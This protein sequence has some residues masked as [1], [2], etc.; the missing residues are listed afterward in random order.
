M[1]G[2]VNCPLTTPDETEQLD[3][4]IGLPSH[5][6]TQDVS[7]KLKSVPVRV[8]AD[9]VPPWS[10]SSVILGAKTVKVSDAEPGI[11]CVP[12]VIVIVYDMKVVG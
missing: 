4:A 9:P 5:R 11:T 6:I 8:T 12:S 1:A 10:G 7:L 3:P 2:T